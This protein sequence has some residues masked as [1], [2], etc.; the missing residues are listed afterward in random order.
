MEPVE[1]RGAKVMPKATGAD[2]GER[3][4]KFTERTVK[5][6]PVPATGRVTYRDAEERYWRLVVTSGGARSFYVAKKVNGRSEKILLG[7][8][9]DLPVEAARKAA[10]KTV[11]AIA[12]GG[13]P[14]D[15]A[16][17]ARSPLT[18]RQLFAEYMTRHARPHKRTADGDAVLFARY[19]GP[20]A[21]HR[22]AAV[23]LRDVQNLHAHIGRDAGPYVAN[24]VLSLLH[25]MFARALQ[26]GF[27][28]NANPA[29][30][31]RKFREQT[32]H[33]FLEPQELPAFFEALRAEPDP[34]FR[35]FFALALFT[36]ARRGNLLAMR[37]ADVSFER[38]LWVIPAESTKTGTPYFVPLI[39]PAIEILANRNAL[40]DGSEFVFPG[41]RGGHLV[42]VKGAW[43]R[44]CRRAG[45]NGLRI[46][47][48][49]RTCAT[50][51]ANAGASLHIVG[52][53]LGHKNYATTMGY[54]RIQEAT[55]RAS[56]ERGAEALRRAAGLL[57]AS[58]AESMDSPSPAIGG[59][60]DDA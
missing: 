30:G 54:A 21:G 5:A 47:D 14:A 11:G 2:G 17:A 43:A 1:P 3:C 31:V 7:R 49:R 35:D 53:S 52:Q 37:W 26:W 27:T 10:Q 56:M 38:E 4:F 41:R 13:N 23:H 57:P 51:Q 44:V 39:A 59:S 33:R 46:H 25:V 50:Y 36:G 15:K 34:I 45:I 16:R 9:P 29:H 20:L 40:A 6:A 22:V 24:R 8:Y 32:R 60:H 55:V 48:L 28:E 58:P 19:C 42:E 18:V 12:A